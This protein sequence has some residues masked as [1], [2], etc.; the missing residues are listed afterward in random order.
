MKRKRKATGVITFLIFVAL[1]AASGYTLNAIGYTDNPFTQLA[2]LANVSEGSRDVRGP[3]ARNSAAVSTGSDSHN[4]LADTSDSGETFTLPPVNDLSSADTS[5][6][7]FALPPVNDLSSAGTGV[8]DEADG[9]PLD[10]SPEGV[11]GDQN[12]VDWS[13]WADVAYDL[14]YICATVASFIVIQQI[15]RFIVRQIKRRAPRMAAAR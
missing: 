2:L 15:F 7:S 11:P 1:I 4:T 10:G 8:S 13:D 3:D 9:A 12:A 14:W 6:D 5:S